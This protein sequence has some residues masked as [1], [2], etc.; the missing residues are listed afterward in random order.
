MYCRTIVF[1]NG[2]HM[3]LISFF[4]LQ[5]SDSAVSL[6]KGVGV[7]MLQPCVLKDVFDEC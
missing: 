2:C 6:T 3:S 1:Q 5:R 4:L 7:E